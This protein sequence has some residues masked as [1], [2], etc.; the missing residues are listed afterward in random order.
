MRVYTS[1]GS[2]CLIATIVMIIFFTIIGFMSRLI[3]A[4]PLGVILLVGIGIWYMTRGRSLQQKARANAQRTQQGHQTE[5]HDQER[6]RSWD[7]DE[8][9]LSRQADDVEFVEVGDDKE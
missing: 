1:N 7:T 2:G 9:E 6:Q 5:N 8:D 4:T 3:F